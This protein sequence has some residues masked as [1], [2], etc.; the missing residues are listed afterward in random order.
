MII[1]EAVFVIKIAENIFLPSVGFVDMA[2]DSV[3][4]VLVVFEQEFYF[5]SRWQDVVILDVIAV[6]FVLFDGLARRKY[7]HARCIE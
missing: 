2:G 7:C 4:Q 1:I 6:L 3:E 5:A